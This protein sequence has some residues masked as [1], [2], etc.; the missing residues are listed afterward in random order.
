MKT[1]IY[2]DGFNLYYGS[3]KGTS[4][5]WLDL[6]KF[7]QQLLPR[8]QITRIKFFSARVVA[9][10]DDPDKPLR[11]QIY[12]RA[13]ATLPQVQIIEG[14]FISKPARMPL[15]KNIGRNTKFVEVMKTEEKGSDVNLAVHLVSDAYKKDFDIAVIIS[16]DSDLLEAVKIVRYELKLSVG[17]INPCPTP[18]WSLTPHASFLKNVR[19]WVLKKSQFPDSLN[20]SVG[21][22]T[23]PQ[24]W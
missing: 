10:K 16:N 9:R 7:C 23:K 5:K 19:N 18:S 24:G 11:Q 3:L 15:V 20:D 17:I 12:W 21:T 22:F 6:Q 4:Y 2:I 1:N 13:L 14:S 8:N